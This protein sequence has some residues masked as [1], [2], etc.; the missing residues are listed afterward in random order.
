MTQRIAVIDHK[1]D[2]ENSNRALYLHAHREDCDT[3]PRCFVHKACAIVASLQLSPVITLYF[4]NPR[5]AKTRTSVESR[6]VC[7]NR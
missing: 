4:I 6:S 5:H 3:A 7:C 1:Y 2:D